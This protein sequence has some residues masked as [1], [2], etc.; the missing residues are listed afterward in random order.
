M[1]LTGRTICTDASIELGVTAAGEALPAGVANVLLSQL[2]RVVDDWN[3][4][5]EAV[6]ATDFLTFTFTPGLNPHTIGPTG[7][8]WT[9]ATQ[10]PVTIEGATV[11][12]TPGANQVNAPQIRMHD[13]SAGIPEWFQSLPTPNITTSYPTD[14][15]YDATW[16]NGSI[17]FWP[18]PS[19]A[20]QCQLQVRGILASYTL[21]TAF[22]MPPG[23]RNAM[24]LT[25]SEY[26]AESFGRP[27]SAGLVSRAFRARARIFGNNTGSGPL[28]TM[29]YGMPVRRGRRS[30]FNWLT[31][32]RNP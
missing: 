31:G 11:V 32:L 25:L 14:G 3:A 15:Y 30:N 13:A 24:T 26:S 16:P 8:T 21:D 10:R 17:Y 28:D 27:L 19:T 18:V 2:S 7:A 9:V 1:S 29:D 4:I 5:R 23:Y 22:S 6:F 20:Y 12:L